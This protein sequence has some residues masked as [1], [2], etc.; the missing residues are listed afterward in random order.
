MKTFEEW[1]ALF[2]GIEKDPRAI[3]KPP[4]TQIDFV[5]GRRHLAECK[6]CTARME[7]VEASNPHTH[8]EK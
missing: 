5:Q 6:E 8:K 4:L 2:T 7:R 1:C 3:V